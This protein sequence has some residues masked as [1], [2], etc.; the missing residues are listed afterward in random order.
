MSG[1]MTEALARASLLAELKRRW[2][3]CYEIRREG[4]WWI[5]K[6]RDDGSE[7]RRGTAAE[8]LEAIENDHAEFPVP[9]EYR[10]EEAP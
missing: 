2:G 1:P 5:A 9:L 4:A 3:H 8:L 6:R 10:T 7:V